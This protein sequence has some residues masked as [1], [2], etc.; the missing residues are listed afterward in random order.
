MI[1]SGYDKLD[2]PYEPQPLR[3]EWRV[4][5]PYDSATASEIRRSFTRKYFMTSGRVLIPMGQG[6]R[7]I[8]CDTVWIPSPPHFEVVC[9]TFLVDTAT[10]LTSIGG[11]DSLID[12]DNPEFRTNPVY[13]KIA[14][15]SGDGADSTT[16]DTTTVLLD[17]FR[18]APGDSTILRQFFFWARAIDNDNP[19]TADPT[20][21][22]KWLYVIDPKH[23][24]ELLIADATISYYLNARKLAPALAFWDEAIERWRPG[25][26][27][28]YHVISQASGNVLPATQL[29]S[30][31]IVI[32]VSDD[33]I[34]SVVNTPDIR[35]RL[36]MASIGGTQIW[37]CG[38][39]QIAGRENYP[40][41]TYSGAALWQI[42]DWMGLTTYPH[43][44][45]HWYA[46][47]EPSV[48]VED[49]IGADPLLSG[50]P[51][52]SVDSGH[53]H[54]RYYWE[55]DWGVPFVDS[56]ATLPEVAGFSPSSEAEIL[57]TYNSLYTGFHPLIIS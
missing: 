55:V 28:T 30:H 21:S 48:R 20:P 47:Q 39:A 42:G 53:L 35:K 3:Y 52:L 37:M 57:Y 12:V 5:G 56:L 2:H 50:W 7:L 45:W 22:F 13:N 18:H 16:T 33:V 27:H 32:V 43:S 38:R 40:P 17:L 11:P 10:Y 19:P 15:H 29:L 24:H 51:A 23:E 6:I 1:W 41:M 31:K 54:S 9:D 14:V 4:Y 46:L 49:F 26:P 8:T 36:M 44:G 25:T 34:Q